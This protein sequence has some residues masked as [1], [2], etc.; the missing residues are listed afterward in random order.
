MKRLLQVLLVWLLIN[1]A[2][3]AQMGDVTQRG[4]ATG[5]MT[6]EG[7][8]AAHFNIPLDSIVSVVN[9]ETLAE[10]SVTI[11]GRIPA[12]ANRV[13]DLSRD[14]YEALELTENTIVMIVFTPPQASRPISFSGEVSRLNTTHPVFNLLI[15]DRDDCEPNSDIEDTDN[16]S[17]LYNFK[18][19][20]HG[21]LIAIYMSANNGLVFPRMPDNSYIIVN[22]ISVRRW[23]IVEYINSAEFRKF[24]SD[25]GIINDLLRV[26]NSQF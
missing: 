7:F 1:T 14:A 16:I 21:Y 13:I 17:V 25:Q 2:A 6:E 26:M 24:V 5:E 19:K 20:E 8:F 15:L 11:A 18:D 9:T 4:R 23:T 12:S 22:M 10:I 3:Y